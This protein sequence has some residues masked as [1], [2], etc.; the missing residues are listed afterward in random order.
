[1]TNHLHTLFFLF[2]ITFLSSCAAKKDLI[3]LQAKYEKA[4]TYIASHTNDTQNYKQRLNTMATDFT[5][6]SKKNQ[7]NEFLLN[8]KLDS[9]TKI[10]SEQKVDLSKSSGKQ[11]DSAINFTVS[12][13]EVNANID[14]TLLQLGQ[15]DKNNT[16]LKS[17]HT[18][19]DSLNLALA[20]NL[21]KVLANQ[22]SGPNVE[23]KVDKTVVMVNLSDKM[24][25]SSG[26]TKISPKANSILE[27][28]AKIVKS[29][30]EL[31]V[32]VEGYT[33]NV[34]INNGCISDNWDLSV[35]RATSVVR[36][37]QQTFNI[38]PNKLIAAGRGEYN[39]LTNNNTIEGRAI[40]RRTRI[41]LMPKVNQ[42][43]DLLNPD[44]K[45]K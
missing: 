41:I 12:S 37:L 28:I 34:A 9:L 11:S 2:A 25:F 16:L 18:K 39:T 36:V 21:N 3:D 29:R 40:N 27:K 22:I 35:K 17:A 7:K 19:A 32:Y 43:Y 44:K 20:L 23:V 1:M 10:L 8:T 13:E 26:S 42:F 38:D 24:L 15:N 31:E 45:K 6:M 33:D 30:P 4:Q 14:K 5:E